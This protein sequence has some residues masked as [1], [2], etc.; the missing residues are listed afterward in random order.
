[1]DEFA[2]E[3][4][5]QKI[6]QANQQLEQSK[7][8]QKMQ[9][10]SRQL[11]QGQFSQ[12][13]SS[14]QQISSALKDFQQTLS[15]AQKEML[16]NQQKETVNT[17]RKAQQNLLEISKEQEDAA[18]PVVAVDAKLRRIAPACRQTK[19]ID[20]GIKL[21]RSAN[22][23]AIEQKFR[24]YSANG[25]TNR[26]GLFAD[27]AGDEQFASRE[28]DQSSAAEPQSN[29]MGSMNQ[30]AMSIQSTLQAMMNG[31]GSGGFMSLM[32]QLQ[33]LA[34]QQ[35]GLNAITQ[36]LGEHGAL[37][38]EQQA[39]LSRLAAQQ[40]AIHKS[41][42]QLAQEAQQSADMNAQN[43]VLGISDR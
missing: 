18:Q 22:D 32:Q 27:A 35:E 14:Q 34:G 4:P 2:N 5:M 21:Y 17:M 39:E 19:R 42:E 6:D 26:R 20:A 30:A 1:M 16:Q 11:S 33:Q 31:Q 12:A 40:E 41:L 13:Q 37:S 15:E 38:M 3:M 43:K 9:N 28:T 24:G 10:S 25:K 8:E 23:A 7:V 29:A 36:K